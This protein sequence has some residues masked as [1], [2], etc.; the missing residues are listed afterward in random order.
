[1]DVKCTP[2]HLYEIALLHFDW[3]V[4]GKRL[5]DL[6]YID[7]ID[8]DEESEQRKR[9]RM[10]EKWAEVKGLQASYRAI[11]DVFKKLSN[12]QAAEAVK[13]FT[14]EGNSINLCRLFSALF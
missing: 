4:V 14:M 5:M 1:M 13:K 2:Q 8:K 12:H 6:R 3:K 7:D 10:L 11:I 9:D